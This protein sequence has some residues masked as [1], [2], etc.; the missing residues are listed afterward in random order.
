MQ[1]ARFGWPCTNP[2]A[3]CSG[4][5]PLSGTAYTGIPVIADVDGT[6]RPAVVLNVGSNVCAID[7]RGNYKW[8]HDVGAP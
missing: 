7:Y 2:T 3:A 1:R 5:L 6:G 4:A 8:C